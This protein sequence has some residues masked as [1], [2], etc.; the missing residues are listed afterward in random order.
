MRKTNGYGWYTAEYC[1]ST[2]LPMFN[3]QTYSKVS[4]KYYSKT[5][6]KKLKM[7]VKEG[8]EPVAFYRV[9]RGYCGLYARRL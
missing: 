4:D 9:G 3:K 7:P 2:G 1:R 5:R 8:E 6:C